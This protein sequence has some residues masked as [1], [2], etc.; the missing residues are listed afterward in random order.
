M[1]FTV[2]HKT[3]PVYRFEVSLY[4]S[5]KFPDSI[6]CGLCEN[7]AAQGMPCEHAA[8]V[9][10]QGVII[11]G[12]TFKLE[13]KWVSE[14][15]YPYLSAE[16]VPSYATAPLCQHL[17]PCRN[18][19]PRTSSKPHAKVRVKR[20]VS[21]TIS[22]NVVTKG[23]GTDFLSS[24]PTNPVASAFTSTSAA[25][26]FLHDA[27]DTEISMSKPPPNE[28]ALFWVQCDTCNKWRIVDAE[29]ETERWVCTMTPSVWHASCD[30]PE[31]E[32]AHSI[33]SQST[34]E[35]H[36]LT[37]D[38]QNRPF[39]PKNDSILSCFRIALTADDLDRL[40]SNRWLND[41]TVDAAMN[42]VRTKCHTEDNF[43]FQRVLFQSYTPFQK[44]ITMKK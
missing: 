31:D 1:L 22:A 5:A 12:L 9:L 35:V 43:Y 33:E 17:S 23:N 44:C 10:S 11:K 38:A 7:T 34:C 21:Q 37:T 42:I 8:F 6:R 20:H 24:S 15:Y 41:N 40:L 16:L 3:K 29:I 18:F 30:D 25:L 27:S 19:G 28:S 32:R 14:V 4:W 2:L 39:N 13:K 26:R 36:D